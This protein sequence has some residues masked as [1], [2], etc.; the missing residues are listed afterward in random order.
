MD[1]AFPQT[2]LPPLDPRLLVSLLLERVG[3]TG[4]DS[5]TIQLNFSESHV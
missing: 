2:W 1:F 4:F 5:L 3:E